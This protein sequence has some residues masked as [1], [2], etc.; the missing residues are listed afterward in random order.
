MYVAYTVSVYSWT[1]VR[2][3]SL[4]TQQGEQRI[5]FKA[6]LLC[7]TWANHADDFTCAGVAR[8]G[9]MQVENSC[10]CAEKVL[11]GL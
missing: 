2:F 8:T 3:S 9:N 4:E 5:A 1:A 11:T 6:S 7:K 10:M